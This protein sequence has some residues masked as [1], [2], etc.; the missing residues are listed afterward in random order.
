M[1]T[2]SGSWGRR[3]GA[4]AGAALLLLG[5]GAGCGGGGGNGGDEAQ[6]KAAFAAKLK[7]EGSRLKTALTAAD[8]GR[9]ENFKSFSG[10]LAHL[11]SVLRRT[12][13]DLDALQAPDD[14]AADTA[15]LADLFR[16]AAAKEGEMATAAKA[17]NQQRLRAIAA[18]VDD[19]LAQVTTVTNDLRAKGYQVG[20][21]GV[22]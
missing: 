11:E 19:L 5:L 12:A 22:G 14:A 16:Q 17:G 3:A 2:T 18:Q 7:S 6:A 8:L 9:A 13:R 20:V 4:A 10:A 1:A 15:K 21:L